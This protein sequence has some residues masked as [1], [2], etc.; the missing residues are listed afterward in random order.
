MSQEH[1]Q[2]FFAGKFRLLRLLGRGAMGEVWLADEVGPRNFR[3]QVAVKR[4]LTTEGISDYARE[5]FIAEAQVIA[6]L[7][8]PN[9]VRLIELGE[10][11]E[12]GLYL[13]LDYIDGAAL[14]RLLRKAGALSPAAVALVGR[15]V[16]RALDAVHSMTDDTGSNLAVVHRDVSPANILVGRDGRE[17]LSDFGVARIHGLGGEKTETGVFKGKLPYMPPEQALGEPFDGRADIFSLGVTIFEALIGGR[18]RKAETQGQLIAKIAT[19]RVPLVHEVVPDALAPL[20]H[21]IDAATAFRSDERYPTAGHFATTMNA[22]LH[23]MGPGAEESAFA[24]LAERVALVAGVS[25]GPT[26]K[27][28]WSLALSGEVPAF[29]Q[30]GSN[31]RAFSTGSGQF[32]QAQLLGPPSTGSYPQAQVQTGSG[33]HSG[34][35]SSGAFRTAVQVPPPP[36]SYRGDVPPSVPPEGVPSVTR[37]ASI[38][39]A[40]ARPKPGPRA[41]LIALSGAAIFGILAGTLWVVVA[42]HGTGE[43]GASSALPASGDG[44]PAKPGP[45]TS[46]EPAIP[47]ASG[48]VA[49][50]DASSLSSASAAPSASSD[51]KDP[52][53]PPT[54]T[55]PV[56]GRPSANP[57]SDPTEDP[58]GTGT[59]QVNV[60][61]W[62][63]VSVDGR[64]Y[65]TTPIGPISLSA[66]NH[67]VT[68]TNPDIGASRSSTVK[69][70]SGKQSSVGFDLKKSQ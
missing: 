22:V 12:R 57:T 59:L 54:R 61:P 41:W 5:S 30:S 56:V 43:A 46:A 21:A 15:E 45:N 49:M 28:P 9:I 62:G 27:Q 8:H 55:P 69:I 24:E 37:I 4:L 14:D 44:S 25:T 36:S 16:A 2:D 26:T 53:R 10:S 66:G 35:L 58:T 70:V 3:R 40:S 64:S 29:N 52:K 42:Q 7:D 34:P 19:E 1:P 47:Q 48:S 50:T 60:S 6:R 33:P 32:A 11:D 20:A 65:G 13:V 17:R 38:S 63:N 68:V 39:D 51:P 31:P 23:A 67:T 18:L